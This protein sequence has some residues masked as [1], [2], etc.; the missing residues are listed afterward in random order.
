LGSYGGGGMR[1]GPNPVATLVTGVAL[2]KEHMIY[3]CYVVL[4]EL[5]GSL[6]DYKVLQRSCSAQ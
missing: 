2:P 4:P 3:Q 6:L 5:L 1:E